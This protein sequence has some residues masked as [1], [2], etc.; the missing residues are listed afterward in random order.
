MKKVKALTLVEVMVAVTIF[1]M[2]CITLF[3]FW[4]GAFKMKRYLLL[5]K[6]N[7]LKSR[8]ALDKFKRELQS[9]IEFYGD[10]RD[11]NGTRNSL[12]FYSIV[13]TNDDAVLKINYL[14]KDSYLMQLAQP[15]YLSDNKNKFVK[16]YMV[17]EC[18]F[19][20]W[21]RNN[22]TWL[23]SWQDKEGLPTAVRIE[24]ILDKK[25]KDWYI[26]IFHSSNIPQQDGDY[27]RL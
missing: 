22:S 19:S 2:L 3:A 26:P 25:T 20:Y 16:K 13:N 23:D 24:Q 14:V 5:A 27:E 17:K 21:D 7:E 4:S 9:S 15:I 18:I 11:F 1:S 8:I 6:R 10:K 12:S